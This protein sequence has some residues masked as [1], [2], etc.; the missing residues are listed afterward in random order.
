MGNF[1]K[2]LLFIMGVWIIQIG[3]SI[4]IQ[5]SIGSDPFTAFTISISKIIG[6]STGTANQIISVIFFLIIIILSYKSIKIGTFIA[7]LIAGPFINLMTFLLFPLSLSNFSII[8]KIPLLFV[9]CIIIAIG[10]SIQNAT[11]LGMAPNDLLLLVLTDKFKT[12]YK[13]VRMTFDISCLIL[14]FIL[15]GSG[16]IGV[17]IGIGTIISA[18]CQGPIIQYFMPKVDNLLEKYW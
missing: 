3:V 5:T 10:F 17:T 8:I 18:L 15:Y 7:L 1:K 9:S 6:I 11:K 16:S 2:I 14:G 13:W 12:Q 4:F